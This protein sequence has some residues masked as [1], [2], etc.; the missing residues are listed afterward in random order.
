LEV[1]KGWGGVRMNKETHQETRRS[2]S[3]LTAKSEVLDGECSSQGMDLRFLL[4]FTPFK[5]WSE[6][7]KNRRGVQ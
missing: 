2:G 1:V 6:D 3:E 4:C 5:G 7:P